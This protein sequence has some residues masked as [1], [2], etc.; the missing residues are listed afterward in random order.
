MPK[1]SPGHAAGTKSERVNG[2]DKRKLTAYVPVELAIEVRDFVHYNSTSISKVLELALID[3]LEAKKAQK[4][5]T[6]QKGS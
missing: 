3:Y 2:P 5:N 6:K 1:E 4:E